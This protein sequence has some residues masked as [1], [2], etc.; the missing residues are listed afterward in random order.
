MAHINNIKPY[1]LNYIRFDA[2]IIESIKYE[3]I[4]YSRLLFRK[5]DIK[6]IIGDVKSRLYN[7][8]PGLYLELEF[9]KIFQIINAKFSLGWMLEKIEENKQP[10][11]DFLV[12]NVIGEPLALFECTTINPNIQ[13]TNKL[14]DKLEEVIKTSEF[15]APE[16]NMSDFILNKL[17]LSEDFIPEYIINKCNQFKKYLSYNPSYSKIYKFIMVDLSWFICDERIMNH[18]LLHRIRKFREFKM[19]SNGVDKVEEL[20]TQLR[21]NDISLIITVNKLINDDKLMVVN[22]FG[23]YGVSPQHILDKSNYFKVWQFDE[24]I[25]KSK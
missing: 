14:N 18:M 25:A 23:I 20:R 12:K 24:K 16:L 9:I 4:K 5:E 2:D 7:Y 22:Q 10:T 15:M 13:N 8:D 17:L 11:V 19:Y 3:K 1:A 21:E 6:C